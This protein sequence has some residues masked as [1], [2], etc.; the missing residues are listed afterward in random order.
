MTPLGHNII[1]MCYHDI[2]IA[3]YLQS[4]SDERCYNFLLFQT[5]LI[6]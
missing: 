6:F 2:I 4:Y 3:C 1:T 5:V